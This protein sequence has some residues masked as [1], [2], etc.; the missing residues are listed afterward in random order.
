MAKGKKGEI[1][2]GVREAVQGY[3]FQFVW[4]ARRCLSMLRPGSSITQIVIDGLHPDDEIDIGEGGRGEML[5]L[6]LTF[7][8]LYCTSPIVASNDCPSLSI[9]I[10]ISPFFILKTLRICLASLPVIDRKAPVGII[11]ST[12]NLLNYSS[13][14]VSF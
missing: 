7:T 12:K 14:L 11:F 1:S 13:F 3:M 2:S 9:R 4:S 10:N 8:S 6:I 5:L